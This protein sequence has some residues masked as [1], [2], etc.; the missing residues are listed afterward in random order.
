MGRLRELK[1]WSRISEYLLDFERCYLSQAGIVILQEAG[2]AAFGAKGTEM[3]GLVTG[4]L[5]TG[6]KYFFI[7]GLPDT[8]VRIRQD[9]CLAGRPCAY[10]GF[11]F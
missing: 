5:L 9:S 6:R 10:I 7:R 11:V 8:A 4:E 3:N 1:P 2:G